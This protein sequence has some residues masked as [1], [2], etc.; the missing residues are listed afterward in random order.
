MLLSRNADK[1]WSFSRRSKV[2]LMVNALDLAFSPDEATK[3]SRGDVLLHTEVA[4]GRTILT[5]RPSVCASGDVQAEA[6]SFVR[7]LI[8]GLS[9]ADSVGY[10]D[11]VILAPKSVPSLP[12]CSYELLQSLT[13]ETSVRF[14]NFYAEGALRHVYC[15]DLDGAEADEVVSSAAVGPVPGL[16][17]KGASLSEVT[18]ASGSQMAAALL[19]LL[20]SSVRGAGSGYGISLE[21]CNMPL[22]PTFDAEPLAPGR[23]VE[24]GFGSPLKRGVSSIVIR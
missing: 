6:D 23:R 4:T 5:V 15:V 21:A 17:F 11:I 19:L 12:S 22:P 3:L 1:G 13:V 2:L 7:A 16:E 18:P 8:R 14:A 24:G 9:Q 20:D 10:S